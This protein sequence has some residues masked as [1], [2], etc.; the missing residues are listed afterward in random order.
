MTGHDRR[1]EESRG[2]KLTEKMNA[3]R[4]PHAVSARAMLAWCTTMGT[5]V[6]KKTMGADV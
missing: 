3:L 4:K 2:E 6:K 1:G 5:D